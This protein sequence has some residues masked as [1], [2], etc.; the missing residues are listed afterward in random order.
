MHPN[1]PLRTA[2]LT[3]T[4]TALPALLTACAPVNDCV[5]A[6]L[7]ASLQIDAAGASLTVEAAGVDCDPALGD[8]YTLSLVT[9]SGPYSL[10]TALPADDGS[11]TATFP[12]P[13]GVIDTPDGMITVSGSSYDTCDDGGDC[14]TYQVALP[15]A[16]ETE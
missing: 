2:T 5:P 6:P 13:L 4:L 14:P 16:D 1:A 9:D 3:L 15:P 7:G 12:V 11:F 8:T 10:G